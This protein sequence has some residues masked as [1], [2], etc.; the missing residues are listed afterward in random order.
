MSV[1][2]ESRTAWSGK[3]RGQGLAAFL[4][5]Q[6][7]ATLEC[8]RITVVTPSQERIEHRAAQ[9][10]PEAT[11]VLHRWRAIRRLV[12]HGDLGFAEAYIDGDWST[13]D[14]AALLELAALNI[15]QLDRK[16][17]G[18]LPVRIFNRLRHVFR[19]NT[20]AGSRKNI[21]FHYDL[22]NA[23]YQC[24]LDESMSYSSALYVRPGQ[25][26]EE[27]Q[28]AKL[29]R[30]VELLDPQ[31]GERVLEI[32]CGWGALA[33]RLAQGGTLVTG[34]T[35]SSEQLA[36]ARQLSADEGLAKAVSL[37]LTDYRDIKGS[38]DRIV[39]IEM[40]E[41][42]GEAYWPV[43]FKTLR[44]RLKAGGTAV[45]Q[46]ITIDESR[47]DTYRSSADFIQRYVFPGGM[48]PTKRIIA[49]QAEAA[50]LK[51]VS[52]ESFGLSY[53]KTLAE[54]RERFVAAWPKI[55]TMGFPA[56]FRRLWEYYLCYCEAG[57]RAGTIDVGFFVLTPIKQQNDA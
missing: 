9:P 44:D 33:A 12:T 52:T 48:L 54:W 53:A 26:L 23:F 8:G 57:F 32:G 21:S 2:S 37:E 50:G 3:R 31:E 36:F 29:E 43:Y 13:P 18:F 47:F 25:T 42:V 14:L 5:R 45:L 11:L 49:R 34:V 28:D 24:W 27:A 22:G 35:L 10:G 15:G 41:A 40:L 38:Y 19:A 4:V 56:R 55:E 7:A 16:I 46:V 6:I 20:K 17:S 30:I 39:S 1:D 51:L